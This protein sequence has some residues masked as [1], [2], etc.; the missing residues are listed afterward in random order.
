MAK[1][2]PNGSYPYLPNQ[3]ACIA[4]LLLFGASAGYHIFQMI[5]KKT[6]FYTSMVIGSI[7]MTIGYVARY[8]SSKNTSSTMLYILQALFIILPPSLY[9]AT[10][11]MIY[12]RITLFVNAPGASLIRPT[13]VT[14]IFVVG[15]VIAFLLQAGGGG[16]M[17]QASSAKLG[18]TIMLM[19]LFIQLI[20][21]GFFLIVALIFWKR[22]RA[23][24]MDHAVPVYGKYT[25]ITLLKLLFCAAALIIFR[26]VF[27]VIEFAQGHNGYLVSRE[28]FLYIFDALPM[29]FVQVMF[30]VVHAGD[31]FPKNARMAKLSNQSESDIGL[32]QRV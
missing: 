9:A 13:H 27:R 10:I 14:K 5:R 31:I 18:Q 24:P 25:W 1:D 3:K 21:F 29:F 7:M 4:A 28:V 2:G 23:H 12:G 15:D 22:M 20:F 16:M 26:C 30:H 6:W 11:Y 32:N 19:G 17:A 8:L